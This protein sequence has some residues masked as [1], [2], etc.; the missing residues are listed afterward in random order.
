MPTFR[1]GRSVYTGDRKGNGC[2][3][4]FL[5]I[6]YAIFLLGLPFFIFKIEFNY[7]TDMASFFEIKQSVHDI[8]LGNK[9]SLMT[10]QPVHW[11]SENIESDVSD[12]AFGTT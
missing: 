5:F 1:W 3:A 6:I 12:Q 9:R 7:L 2:L 10:N 8:D 4:V 11:Q